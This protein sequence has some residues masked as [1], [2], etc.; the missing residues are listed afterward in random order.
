MNLRLELP[1]EI[2]RNFYLDVAAAMAV[3]F[4]IAVTLTFVPVVARRLGADFAQMSLIA[5]APFAGSLFTPLASHYLQGRRKMPFLVWFWNIARGLFTL[6][7]FVTSP[8]PLTMIVLAFNILTAFAVPGYA[9]MMRLVYPNECRGRAMSYVRVGMTAVVTLMTPL[10]GRL[11]DLVGYRYLFPVGAAF[12]IASS[13]IFGR[14]RVQET[15]AGDRQPFGRFW[16]ILKDDK[17]FAAYQVAFMVYGFGNLMALPVFP[18]FQVDVLGLTYSQ[19]GVLG[20]IMAVFWLLSYVYWGRE[21]DRRGGLWTV[22]L[23]FLITSL[24]FLAYVFAWDVRLVAVAFVFIGITNAGIDLGWMNALMQ[25]APAEKVSEYASLHT[26]LLGGR[27]LLA[28][29]VGIAL[30]QVP[31]IGFKGVFGL[32]FL[33]MVI[34]WLLL[35][36]APRDARTWP[37]R[38]GVP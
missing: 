5:A 32:C 17:A 13:T 38:R 6:T 25:F 33:M 11:L 21:V 36:V 22:K 10:A 23:N 7:L 14:I 37:S 2:R 16:R 28:P 12:G 20:F 15:V 4:F 29:F 30:L 24:V 18:V 27:G 3:G 26:T 35:A 19:I 1:R 9:E 31:W 8:L 34:S